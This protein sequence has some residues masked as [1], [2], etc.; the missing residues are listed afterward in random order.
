MESLIPGVRSVHTTIR[1]D[2]PETMPTTSCIFQLWG[3]PYPTTGVLEVN[4]I[5]LA[6]HSKHHRTVW[7]HHLIHHPERVLANR[8]M[9]YMEEGVPIIYDG[10]NLECVLGK[11]HVVHDCLTVCHYMG[12]FSMC[13]QSAQGHTA[14]DQTRVS[15]LSDQI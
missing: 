8:L 15:R 2:D 5:M 6:I 9:L 11:I 13:C 4:H 14:F 3:V 12:D 10:P 7:Q 1:D